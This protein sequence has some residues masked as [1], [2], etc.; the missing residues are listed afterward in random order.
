MRIDNKF[1]KI[2]GYPSRMDR[3]RQ[4]WTITE[5]Q[6]TNNLLRLRY[7]INSEVP[8][9]GVKLAMEKPQEAKIIWNGKIVEVNPDGYFTDKSIITFPIPD[10]VSGSNELLIEIPFGRLTNVEWCY[11]LGDFGVRVRGAH[12]SLEALPTDLAFGD[13]TVQGLPFYAGN[14][15]YQC[16]LTLMEDIPNAVL[17]I[18]H[19]SGPVMAV[20]LNQKRKGLIAYAPHRLELGDLEAGKHQLTITVYGNRYNAFG[21]LHNAN[22]EFR[23]YGPDSYRTKGSQWTDTYL[24]RSMGILSNPIIGQRV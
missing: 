20:A 14:L 16:T 17:E 9:S 2:L 21:T 8:F 5:P 4:P 11:L 1:R 12:S 22:D 24:L 19:F 10:I 18:P 6:P 13:W 7:R 23:W 3:L 15:D